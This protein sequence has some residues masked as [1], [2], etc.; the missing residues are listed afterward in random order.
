MELIQ[1]LWW[2]LVVCFRRCWCEVKLTFQKKDLSARISTVCSCRRNKL[3]CGKINVISECRTTAVSG[4]E[5]ERGRLMIQ[6][7]SGTDWRQF[8]QLFTCSCICSPASDID[9][10]PRC[11]LVTSLWVMSHVFPRDPHV[12]LSLCQILSKNTLFFCNI[13]TTIKMGWSFPLKVLK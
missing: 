7:R 3:L 2:L 1:T 13:K 10:V 11:C 6:G 9:A 5:R 12:P 4:T 8:L